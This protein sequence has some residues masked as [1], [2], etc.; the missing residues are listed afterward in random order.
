ML[1]FVRVSC[2]ANCVLVGSS[3]IRVVDLRKRV[4]CHGCCTGF[5]GSGVSGVMVIMG[6]G[7]KTFSD[8]TGFK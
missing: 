4:A 8:A 7:E 5:A 3:P 6:S 2:Q 1:A